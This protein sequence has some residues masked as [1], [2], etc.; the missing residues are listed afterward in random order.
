MKVISLRWFSDGIEISTLPV[1]LEMNLGYGFGSQVL[2]VLPFFYMMNRRYVFSWFF[3]TMIIY[4]SQYQG[5]FTSREGRT[6]VDTSRYFEE[7]KTG[8]LA[9]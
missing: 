2:P 1:P 7:A 6:G 8:K 5:S 9:Y 3:R 4:R